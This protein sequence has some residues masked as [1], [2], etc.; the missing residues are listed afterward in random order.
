MGLFSVVEKL[1][2]IASNIQD[3]D[4]DIPQLHAALLA[5]VQLSGQ[6]KLQ[7]LKYH[8]QSSKQK[9]RN[10]A[11]VNED[12][13]CDDA[14]MGSSSTTSTTANS[15]CLH[16]STSITWDYL[17]KS[18]GNP[19]ELSS[20]CLSEIRDGAKK[21][22]LAYYEDPEVLTEKLH[23]IDYSLIHH[24]LIDIWPRR[25]AHYVAVSPT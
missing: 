19:L 15:C 2:K 12:D 21:A 4:I 23:A 8:H 18:A 9:R 17:Y 1:Q 20:L 24:K 13:K 16:M 11:A 22:L 3:L 7:Q 10:E 5:Y 14:S 25:V 6:N